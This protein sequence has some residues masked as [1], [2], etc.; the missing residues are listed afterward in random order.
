[1]S[2][3]LSAPSVTASE[4]LHVRPL[5]FVK[6]E[7]DGGTVYAHN[8]V[9]TYTWDSQTWTGIGAIGLIGDLEESTELSPFGVQMT[10]N[11]L[12]ADLLATAE[13]EEVFNRP[14]T[15]YIGLLDETGVLVDTPSER[16]SGPMD[17]ISIRLGGEDALTLQCE[18]HLRFF[19]QANGAT[20]TDE[21]Q[22][23][24][25]SGDLF[26]QYLPQIVDARVFWPGGQPVSLGF[27][28]PMPTPGGPNNEYG[29]WGNP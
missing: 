27:P 1:M 5:V 23:R 9:G 24:R 10:L 2:R 21:W 13:S 25:Y 29:Y 4:A 15:I 14:A 20:F 8:G 26:F 11:A 19:D 12:D 28:V 16:W 18:N 22:Q 3:G 6:L 17:S 7:F